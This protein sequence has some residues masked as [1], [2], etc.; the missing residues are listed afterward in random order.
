MSAPGS[1]SVDRAGPAGSQT[2]AEHLAHLTDEV[3]EFIATRPDYAEAG[4]RMGEVFYLTGRDA[5]AAY[6]GAVFTE[7]IVSALAPL[8]GQETAE[9]LGRRLLQDAGLARWAG[10]VGGAGDRSEESEAIRAGARFAVS[11]YVERA[12]H[13]IP[14]ISSYLESVAATRDVGRPSSATPAIADPM[15][16]KLGNSRRP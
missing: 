11:D 1:N 15:T 14:T 3:Y 13:A 6:I 16:P 7:L 12:L 5:E 9:L 8:E 10:A 2:A 4:R